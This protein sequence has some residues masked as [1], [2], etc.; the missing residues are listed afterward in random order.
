MK[1]RIFYKSP[2]GILEIQLKDHKIYSVLK[3]VVPRNKINSLSD[4]K[5]Q[6]NQLQKNQKSKKL[7]QHLTL[8][9]D[10]YFSGV[11]VKNGSL[12]LFSRGTVF[13]RKVWQSLTS[14]PY[15]QTRTYKQV[16]QEVSSA[17]AARAV[18]S[19]CAQNP[20]LI[21]VPCH[22]VVSQ[23]GLGG[24]SLGLLAKNSLLKIETTL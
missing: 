14:I 1:D 21:L 2:L 5:S 11:E 18:G 24:F 6:L 22:R 15:G 20:Y 16:A 19:A 17:K 23:K 12:P 9:L 8:F 7:I 4:M 3:A 13:Q 10:N